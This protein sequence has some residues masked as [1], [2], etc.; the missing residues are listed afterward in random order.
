VVAVGLA[1]V[2]VRF[3]A[4][5]R[6]LFR[7]S[8]RLAGHDTALRLLADL[9]VRVYERLE[10]LAPA[11][12]PAF[13]RGDLLARLVKD[14]DGI[15]DLSLKVIAPYA[16]ALVVA[17]PTVALTW[18][19]LP[20]AGLLMSV[21]LFVGMVLVPWWNGVLDRRRDARLAAARGELSACVVDLLAGASDLVAYGAMED[22]LA[23]VSAVD[24]EITRISTAT[25]RSA[26]IGSG[27]ITLLGGLTVWGVLVLAVPSVR[28]GRVPGPLLA[29]LA[30]VP[31]ALFELISGLPLAARTMTGVRQS[32][33]RVSEVMD[34]P[35]PLN[36]PA[37]PRSLDT[38]TPVIRIRGLRA[39]Y[40]SREDWALDG[41]DLDLPVGSRV[42][43]VGASGAGKSTLAAVLTRFLPY[44]SGSV[45]LDGI[46]LR[47]LAGEAVRK[48]VGLAAQ[49][50]HVFNTSIRENLMLAKRD[51]TDDEIRSAI[52]RVHL[53]EWVEELPE[54]LDTEVGEYG[55]RASGGERQRICLARALLPRFPVLILDEPTEHLDSATAHALTGDVLDGA[56]GQ[57]IL[58]ISHRLTG[59]ENL[60]EIVVVDDG[61]V[62]ER[63]SH[64]ELMELG[65][66]YA[67]QWR[68]QHGAEARF[69]IVR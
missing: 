19:V 26:G 20:A 37:M 58:L 35:P 29:V 4:V 54:G 56:N 22:H 6:G 21:M 18:Y 3:F 32:I 31:L 36:D 15:Q 14:V 44:E 16:V 61:K 40:G 5:S 62:V 69:E 1:I 7:Y 55:Q 12:L 46:E 59:M 52:E 41:I 17:V 68:R 13:R 34:T 38:S 47:D 45:T 9:R 28:S 57:T 24:S 11:G 30:L 66:A 53:L 10:G 65:G 39:R 51:A 2:G 42:G 50:S 43:V 33:S 25:A 64:G 63:G 67:H 27:L 8:E 23:Q 48:V 49:D 60:D